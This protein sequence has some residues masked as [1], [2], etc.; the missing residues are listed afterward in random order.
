[1]T[2]PVEVIVADNGSTDQSVKIAQSSGAQVVNVAHKGYGSA[3][4]GGIAAACGT[5]IIMGDADASYDFSHI[6]RFLAKLEGGHDL[7][8]GNRFQGGIEPGA[9]PLLHRY[10][11]NPVLSRIGRIFF[12][13]RIGDFH[14]GLRGF[15]KSSV[16]ALNLQTPGMEFCQRN[17]R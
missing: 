9:M 4:M 17:D 15:R 5:Y 6:P 8:I 14:C 12:R 2:L 7:V 1:M 16:L 11:G 13:C 10:L 3:L